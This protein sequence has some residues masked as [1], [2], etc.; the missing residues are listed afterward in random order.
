MS[1][2][3]GLWVLTVA[4]VLL[5]V[6]VMARAIVR[7]RRPRP[8]TRPQFATGPNP[9]VLSEAALTL[10]RLVAARSGESVSF[11]EARDVLKTSPLQTAKVIEELRRSG[12]VDWFGDSS[13]I[14]SH[15]Y[16]TVKGRKY[17]AQR[18][19]G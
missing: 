13:A 5:V 3:R 15:G 8:R 6:V 16:V 17:L 11:M 7:R 2:G 12:F 19:G 4:L 14:G 18:P 9:V 10:L 1:D